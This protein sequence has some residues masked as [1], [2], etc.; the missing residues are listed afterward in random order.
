MIDIEVDLRTSLSKVERVMKTKKMMKYIS[1]QSP[2]YLEIL[3]VKYRNKIRAINS[4]ISNIID[5]KA[6][7]SIFLIIFIY[8]L[9]NCLIE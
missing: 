7:I 4:M 1:F 5:I 6:N 2:L 8:K 3:Q 9:C